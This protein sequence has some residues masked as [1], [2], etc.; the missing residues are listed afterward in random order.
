MSDKWKQWTDQVVDGDF[1][2]R[3][4]IGGSERSG[5]FL[6]ERAPR[7]NQIAAIKLIVEEPANA[8]TRLSQW[9]EAAKLPHPNLLRLF[10][11][12]RSKLDDTSLLYL[13]MEYAEENLSQVLPRRPLSTKETREMLGPAITALAYL[14]SKEFVHGGL[15]PANVMANNDRLKLSSDGIRR[16]GEAAGIA[17][18]LSVYDPPEAASGSATEAGDVWSLGV[19][20]VEALTQRL[21]AWT[22][23][24]QEKLVL[25][26]NMSEPF[27]SV[28]RGCLQRDPRSRL[29]IAGIAGQLQI[30]IS[31]RQEPS[32]APEPKKT[33]ISKTVVPAPRKS[34]EAKYIVSTVA[35]CLGLVAILVIPKFFERRVNTNQ[36]PTSAVNG[37]EVRTRHDQKASTSIQGRAAQRTTEKS[38]GPTGSVP[39]ASSPHVDTSAKKYAGDVVRG[40]VV[41]QVLPNVPQKASDTISGK[42]VVGVGISVDASGNVSNVVIA[43]PGPSKYF[44][45]LAF[46]AAQRWTF[47]AAKA[48]GQNVPSEWLVRFEF[49]KTGNR[50]VPTET[51]P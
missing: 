30:R 25:P 10:R 43:S 41:N 38:Q 45:N 21:P 6:T 23:A 4:Y 50:A 24:N 36:A 32:A 5:V 22:D 33:E 35:L 51:T 18:T 31:A 34:G 2:L 3:Q 29:T 37:S 48:D 39:A 26:E 7:A 28:A 16:S 19:T 44:A 17:R 20:L 9:A 1:C 49:E 15:K 27:L 8:D 40:Q 14:H 13:V 46:Q 12:G 42:V 11:W 47:T